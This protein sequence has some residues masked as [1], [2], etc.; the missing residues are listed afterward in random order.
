MQVSCVKAKF[1]GIGVRTSADVAMRCSMSRRVLIA[2]FSDQQ[3]EPLAARD[4][5]DTRQAY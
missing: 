5:E 2:V 3:Q 1:V 4:R